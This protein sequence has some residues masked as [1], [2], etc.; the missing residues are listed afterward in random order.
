MEMLD[1]QIMT[2]GLG[3]KINQGIIIYG[4]SS[5]GE[6][7]IMLLKQLNLNDKILAI[8]DSDEKKWGKTCLGYEIKKPE[9]IDTFSSEVIII[10]ASVYLNEIFM[11]LVNNYKCKQNLCSSF[12]FKHAIHY[13]LMNDKTNIF[14]T[15][16][17]L[18]YR[19][20]YELWENALKLRNYT[21]QQKEYFETVKCI[22]ENPVSILLCGIQKTGNTSL[23]ASFNEKSKVI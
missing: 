8:I 21:L 1:W 19:K 4:A 14:N 11:Q 9:I 15:E 2:T 22:I 12:A 7:V 18:Q 20:K 5:N 17:T 10:I 6:R 13:E 16:V 3:N 23:V